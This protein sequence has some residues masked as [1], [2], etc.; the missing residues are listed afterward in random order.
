M[1]AVSGSSSDSEA[2]SSDSD[3]SLDDT[4]NRTRDKKDIEGFPPSASDGEMGGASSNKKRKKSDK[5]ENN[6]EE[7]GNKTTRENT[8][9]QT[10][11]ETQLSSVE[12]Q[13]RGRERER[14]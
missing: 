2:I 14:N 1:E 6:K 3:Q 9:A 10:V 12:D 5:D 11:A 7:Q 8:G 4:K 13:E